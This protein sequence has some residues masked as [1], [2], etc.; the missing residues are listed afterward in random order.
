[1]KKKQSLNNESKVNFKD[2][3]QLKFDLIKGADSRLQ[4][5][6]S[7]FELDKRNEI[8]ELLSG[9][10]IDVE[11]E[12]RKL[13]KIISQAI[14]SYSKRVPTE[15]Y[16]EIFRLNN[17]TCPDGKYYRKPSIV[18]R[19]TN[20]IIYSRFNL[21]IISALRK[22][23]PYVK[24]GKRNYKHFQ[25]MTDEGVQDFD[26]FI[27]DAITEMKKCRTWYEFRKSHSEKFGIFF[28]LD[29]TKV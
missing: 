19:F 25:L 14:R 5:K 21:S 18:G 9:K 16:K 28:Q 7:D 29:F 22:L 11:E 27:Q 4:N 23:N 10:F 20:E 26:I 6:G 2:K 12:K 13:N 1:M 24:V 17:W 8:I 15:F 3:N